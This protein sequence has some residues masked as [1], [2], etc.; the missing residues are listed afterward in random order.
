MRCRKREQRRPVLLTQ[1][2]TDLLRELAE[3]GG[4]DEIFGN[5][6]LVIGVAWRSCET[7]E[8]RELQH[9]KFLA[10]GLV[11]RQIRKLIGADDGG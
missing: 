10:L 4:I 2:Q 7:V 11:R 8:A 9:A 5:V 6:E 1:K 3:N